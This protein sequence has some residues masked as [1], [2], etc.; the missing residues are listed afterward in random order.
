MELSFLLMQQICQLFIMIFLGFMLVKTKT[1]STQDSK[2]I[3][4]VILFVVSPC[5]ILT[6]FMIFLGSNY[7]I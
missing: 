6:S 2:V 4:K 3:S 1:L 7:K 5:A